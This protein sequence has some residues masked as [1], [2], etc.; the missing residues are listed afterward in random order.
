MFYHLN[1]KCHVILRVNLEFYLIIPSLHISSYLNG[2][3]PNKTLAL[4]FYFK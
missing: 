3:T 2:L 1:K 4:H